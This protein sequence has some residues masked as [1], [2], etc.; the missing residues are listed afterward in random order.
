[1]RWS[2]AARGMS[3]IAVAL[4]VTAC[5]GGSDDDSAATATSAATSSAAEPSSEVPEAD[6][7]FCT[8]AEEINA[9][10]TRSLTESGGESLSA[11]LQTISDEIAA[12]EAPDE[13]ADDWTAL[14]EALGKA[15][16]ALEGVDLSDPDQAA[17]AQAEISGLQTELGDAGTNVETYLREQCGLYDEDTAA[18]S[19]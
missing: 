7:E 11:D 14:G 10:I 5:G 9:R 3:A 13:I 19:S 15:A 2:L 6:S 12:V 17:E 4:L 1:M 16:D 8:Q 18:P